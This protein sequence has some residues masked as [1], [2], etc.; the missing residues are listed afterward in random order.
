M[1]FIA[2][3]MGTVHWSVRDLFIDVALGDERLKP[4]RLR[5]LSRFHLHEQRGK[6]RGCGEDV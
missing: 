3:V 1:R 4:I 6:E 5:T 2:C